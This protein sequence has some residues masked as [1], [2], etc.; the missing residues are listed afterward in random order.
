MIRSPYRNEILAA[1][2]S[3]ELA[4]I[5]PLLSRVEWENGQPL[6]ERLNPIEQMY[7]AE[8]GFASM[9]A[10]ADGGVEVGLAGRETMIGLIGAFDPHA[11]ST[12]YSCRLPAAHFLYRQQHCVRIFM[13]CRRSACCYFAPIRLRS[14]KAPKPRPAISVTA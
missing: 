9:V 1:L 4:A 3:H 10:D 7:F 11:L 14:P 8:Q 2:P 5:L 13:H 6:Q 12:V